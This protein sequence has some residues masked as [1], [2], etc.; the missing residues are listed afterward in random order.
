MELIGES[1]TSRFNYSC[2]L[3]ST[4]KIYCMVGRLNP[5]TH[6]GANQV[7][8]PVTDSWTDAAEAPTHTDNPILVPHG[9]D[10]YFFNSFA[11]QRGNAEYYIYN[12]LTDS[13]NGAPETLTVADNSFSAIAAA[14]YDGSIYLLG[15]L[16]EDGDGGSGDRYLNLYAYNPD[17]TTW[18]TE[19]SSLI[20]ASDVRYE[21]ASA[22]IGS[23]LYIFGG[24]DA[25]GS[26]KRSTLVYDITDGTITEKADMPTYRAG[27][28]ITVGADGEIYLFGGALNPAEAQDGIFTMSVVSY[29]P[30]VN[31][32]TEQPPLSTSNSNNS[33]VLGADDEI[34]VFMPNDGEG[35]V[36]GPAI[37]DRPIL[38]FY[39]DQDNELPVK[40]EINEELEIYKGYA[41]SLETALCPPNFQRCNYHV[42]SDALNKSID[43]GPVLSD[44]KLVATPDEF[45]MASMAFLLPVADNLEKVMVRFAEN[46]SITGSSD[47]DGIFHFPEFLSE[48]SANP[49]GDDVNIDKIIKLGGNVS[50]DLSAPARMLIPGAGDADYRV[51]YVEP[52]T[53]EFVEIT[54]ICNEDT[55]L[56]ATEQLGEGE[57]CKMV[58]GSDSQAE[59][60]YEWPSSVVVWTTHFTEFLTYESATA[61]TDLESAEEEVLPKTGS[62]GWR[63]ISLVDRL[64]GSLFNFFRGI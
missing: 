14:S 20:S 56:S 39:I 34:Y 64:V 45:S 54:T 5:W 44:G 38:D 36:S 58:L 21:A 52:G 32:W 24:A 15:E 40:W 8:D 1:T 28:A 23:K 41:P 7:Y 60:G 62:S 37:E 18:S 48:S 6:T 57:A 47:W 50:L 3:G 29:D 49:D 46:V 4:D 42:S 11:G 43:L 16:Y 26:Y 30:V 31:S 55:L 13:W 22:A 19:Y 25:S 9:D 33:A 12:A 2:A 35:G 10:I 63:D 51:G 17:T 59:M 61:D 53:D 27:A